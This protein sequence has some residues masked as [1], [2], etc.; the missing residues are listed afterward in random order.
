MI[1]SLSIWFFCLFFSIHCWAQPDS[2]KS[3]T[4]K[5]RTI[6]TQD[7]SSTYNEYIT[8]KKDSVTAPKLLLDVLF[9]TNEDCDLYIN[10]ESKGP[11][12]KSEFRYLKLATG[13]Y[14]Y[15]AKSKT[16]PD[17]LKETFTVSEGGVNEIF[18]DLLY[19]VDE[20]NRQRDSLK[21]KLTAPVQPLAPNE[22]KPGDN[23][24]VAS[25][26]ETNDEA[27][28]TTINFFIDNM[29]L[30]KGGNFIMGNNKA[31]FADEM[32]HP[33]TINSLFFSKYEVTQ[34][35]WESIMGNNPSLSKGCG[36][37]PVENISWEEALKF[38][39]KINAISNKKF[40]LPTEA[41]WEYVAR[42]GGKAEIETAGGQEE[43]IKKTAWYFTNSDQRTHPVGRKQPNVSGIYDLI[44]NVSE[45]CSD[46]YGAYYYKEDYNQKNPE[47]PPLGKDKI[48]RGG[49]FKD[50][51]G[52]RFRPS[53]RNKTKPTDKRGE[54]GFRLVM[55]LN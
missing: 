26:L 14:I 48:I 27:E 29:I 18:M 55:E 12:S 42:R 40:R 45:W 8:A 33:V 43:Y 21:N 46:W 41:E 35:Q 34:H 5:N 10:E 23:K 31:P 50:Y 20:K 44:G 39:R 13:N 37:C 11:V 54:I 52:D 51:S 19:V 17:E 28:R 6:K 36:T 16:T 53:L 22:N 25:K 49:N 47:G 38:I 24:P 15:K 1:K 3:K 9:A 32:E 30:I 7:T 2:V 4:A